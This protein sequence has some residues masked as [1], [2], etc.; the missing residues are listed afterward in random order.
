MTKKSKIPYIFFAFFA[1]IF[2][3]D[4]FYIYIAGKTWRGIS[5]KDSYQKGLNY[6][7]TIQMVKNQQDLGWKLKIKYRG[8]GNKM[9]VLTAD[10]TDKNARIIKDAEV[11]VNFRRPTQEGFDFNWELKFLNNQYRAE[12]VFPL[13]GQWDFEIVAKGKNGEVLQEVKRYVVQ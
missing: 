2:L 11:K 8:D 6:N 12:I 4:F 5:T 9:G 13:K 10:L 3:V 1:V 7:Q